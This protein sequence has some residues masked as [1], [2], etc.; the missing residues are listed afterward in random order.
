M[1]EPVELP[2]HEGTFFLGPLK[3]M[4]S[5]SLGPIGGRGERAQAK[6]LGLDC[7]YLKKVET[8]SPHIN[9]VRGGCLLPDTLP[10]DPAIVR[11]CVK[12]APPEVEMEEPPNGREPSEDS[13]FTS[14]FLGA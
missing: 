6:A 7:P 5:K 14:L 12:P 4:T 10:G 2:G 11:V 1:T 3:E 9:F 13:F 8:S